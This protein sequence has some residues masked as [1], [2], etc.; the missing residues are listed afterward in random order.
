MLI[1]APS[2]IVPLGYVAGGAVLTLVV[3]AIRKHFTRGSDTLAAL[4]A[5]PVVLTITASLVLCA[6]VA[7]AM[8]FV[9]SV[10]KLHVSY[11]MI[12]V[13]GA[14]GGLAGSVIRNRNQLTLVSYDSAECSVRLGFVG[15]MVLGQGGATATV[16]LLGSTL[17]FSVDDP[18]TYPLMIS[19]AMIAGVFGQLVIER[20]GREL[21]H[22]VD[23]LKEQTKKLKESGATSLVSAS[24]VQYEQGDFQA[25]LT[26]AQKALEMEPRNIAA[27][28]AK[29][30]ALKKL[31]KLAEALD[32]T[33]ARLDKPASTDTAAQRAALIY[34]VVCYRLLLSKIQTTEALTL[35]KEAFEKDPQL[36]KSACTDSDLKTLWPDPQFQ[37]LSG[38]PAPGHAAPAAA[39]PVT[40]T[41]PP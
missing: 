19:I 30:R 27:T 22:D 41:A 11:W 15:D 39:A 10:L 37:A 9:H 18:K 16:F 26:A 33:Q 17:N 35:L 7:L 28:V 4:R 38:C 34:N 6:S 12:P 24:I 23:G 2:Y 8:Y 21:Q 40:P 14:L 29:A 1:Q 20:A 13:F 32:V 36:K 5:R 3:L 31:G 25:A